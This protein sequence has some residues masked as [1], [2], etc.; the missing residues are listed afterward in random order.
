MGKINASNAKYG[1]VYSMVDNT[2]GSIDK[3]LVGDEK[4]GSTAQAFS[5]IKDFGHS[6]T[7]QINPMGG[8]INTGAKT[9]GHLIGGTKD[10]VEGTG[11][12]IQGMVS[13]G[14]SLLGP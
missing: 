11:S 4:T 9:L 8:M 7:S 1:G 5:G 2:I 10:R 14:L 13:D 3:A 12:Q 6:I